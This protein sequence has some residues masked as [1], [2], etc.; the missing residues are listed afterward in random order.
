MFYSLIL[1]N[2]NSANINERINQKMDEGQVDMEFKAKSI[3]KTMTSKRNEDMGTLLENPETQNRKEST[4]KSIHE[5]IQK[6]KK[7]VRANE[8]MI[9]AL[10]NV[11]LPGFN[12][13]D[14]EDDSELAAKNHYEQMEIQLSKQWENLPRRTLAEIFADG[15]SFDKQISLDSDL[16]DYSDIQA[17]IKSAISDQFCEFKLKKQSHTQNSQKNLTTQKDM[18]PDV[19]TQ[20][21]NKEGTFCMGLIYIRC[22][23][24]QH[25]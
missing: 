24:C 7:V 5:L 1:E 23:R 6:N 18:L 2:I 4:V 25:I 16:D 19:N 21:I 13:L 15:P 20:Q 8:G 22:R 14:V 9:S 3:V 17:N 10:A 11:Y 12:K